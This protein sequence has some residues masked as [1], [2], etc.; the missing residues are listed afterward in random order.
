MYTTPLWLE[1]VDNRQR[2][3]S[4]VV[5]RQ[6]LGFVKEHLYRVKAGKQPDKD[7]KFLYHVFHK[8]GELRRLIARETL[9]VH[10]DGDERAFILRIRES[11]PLDALAMSAL[12]QLAEA[13][14]ALIEAAVVQRDWRY[15]E[16]GDSAYLNDWLARLRRSAHC[17]DEE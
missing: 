5:I 11:A 6:Y 1:L 17:L 12:V 15:R 3:I 7:S 16:V 13:Q 8:L 9:K 14:L 4:E 10:L 2:F